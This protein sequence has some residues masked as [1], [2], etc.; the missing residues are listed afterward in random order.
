MPMLMRITKISMIIAATFVE[1]QNE[2]ELPNDGWNKKV[3]E[4]NT[5]LRKVI[6]TAKIL[7]RVIFLI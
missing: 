4:A 5:I 3:V 7:I 2:F 1:F 6:C